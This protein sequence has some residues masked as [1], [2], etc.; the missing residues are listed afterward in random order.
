MAKKATDSK[1]LALIQE[2]K[3]RKAEIASAEKPQYITN[4]NFSYTEDSAKIVNIH[5]ESDVGH[6]VR[7]AG[8][9]IGQAKH[10]AEASGAMGIED[11]PAFTWQGFSIKDWQNDIKTRLAKL[12][13][14]NKRKK[15]EALESR[16]NT[17]I[18]P[19]L[20][21]EMELEAIAIELK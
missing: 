6:L 18:S 8:F 1:T 2:V 3:K 7:I 5:V 21:A 12:Q 17:I 9:L 10:Y 11:V 20:R 19:E 13:I 4:C 14:A 15:L 16:L